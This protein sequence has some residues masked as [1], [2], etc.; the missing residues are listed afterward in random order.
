[1]DALERIAEAVLYEGYVLWPYTRSARKNQ[2]R[3]TFGG[4][5]PRAFCETARN[6]D[7]WRIQT[8]VLVQG[9]SP[10]V[11]AELRCLH[12]VQRRVA[13]LR[14]TGELD[15]VDQ[16]RDG[17]DH[18]L[19]WDEAVERRIP[20]P[21]DIAIPAGTEHDPLG[22]GVVVRSWEALSGSSTVLT[23]PSS[24]GV[25]R[26]TV[27][28]ANSSDWF[29]TDRD[30][31]QRRSFIS[32]HLVLRVQ[33]GDFVSA[34][35]PP[36][37]LASQVSACTNVGVWPVLVGAE[38]DHDTLL[39]SPI[40]L[41]DY[42]Q[43]AAQSPGLLFDSGEIDQM[44]MLNTL[45]LT[46]AEKAEMRATDPRTRAIL[47]RA[48]ALSAQDFASL[49]GVLHDLER[50]TPSAVIVQGRAVTPGTRVV[51]HPRLGGDIFD[52]A[53]DGRAATVESIEQDYNERLHLAVTL[54]DDPGSDLGRQR[55]PGHR[56]FFAPEEVEPVE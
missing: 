48:E 43:I 20:L 34:T 5:Y 15:F 19:P 14:P 55:L 52:L 45:T 36:T 30:A 3:W 53:L 50:P 6:G 24:D 33:H 51:L 39:A 25:W 4:V 37:V 26:V 17:T 42:P 40:I 46:D 22:D 10:R 54:A 23:E 49:H 21:G 11:E 38:G 18:I 13:R 29:G 1:M 7:A 32:A 2:Q 8:Q 56:F 27:T 41:Y 16:L 28:L 35:D 44:L 9:S 12:I 47:D 31:A